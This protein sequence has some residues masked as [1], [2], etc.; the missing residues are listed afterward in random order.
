MDIPSHY[1]DD[2]RFWANFGKFM[3]FVDMGEFCTL[4]NTSSMSCIFKKKVEVFV[5]KF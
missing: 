5:L 3:V 2:T 1:T 4:I